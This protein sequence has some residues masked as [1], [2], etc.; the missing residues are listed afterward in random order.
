MCITKE[1]DYAINVNDVDQSHQNCAE[2]TPCQKDNDNPHDHNADFI[3]QVLLSPC[4]R[5]ELAQISRN[6][7][8]EML[9]KKSLTTHYKVR[10][11]ICLVL[12]TLF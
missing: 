12:A 3:T 7:R 4:R 1:L 2:D 9:N 11:R 5:K 6:Y 10:I 8:L